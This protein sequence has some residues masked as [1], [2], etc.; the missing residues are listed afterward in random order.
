MAMT[1]AVVTGRIET[2]L[3]VR[4]II[5][6]EANDIVG[7]IILSAPCCCFAGTGTLAVEGF[8]NIF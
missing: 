2:T 3:D 1:F 6:T 5:W 7:A 8:S 4:R